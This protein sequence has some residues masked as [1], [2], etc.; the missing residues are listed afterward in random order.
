MA[1]YKLSVAARE[2]LI[3][4]H[5]YGTD[6]FGITQADQYFDSFFEYFEVIANSPFSFQ[7]VDFVKAGYRRCV[8]G[9]DSIYYKINDDN[10][11]EIM[12]IIGRQDLN[13]IL[14]Y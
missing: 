5:H 11:V 3:R 10:I 4:I 8:C 6:K 2:D 14:K 13:N 7:S 1:N 12:A 9:V